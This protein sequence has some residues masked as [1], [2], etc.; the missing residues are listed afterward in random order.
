[1]QTRPNDETLNA[2]IFRDNL[3]KKGN[4]LPED[5][6]VPNEWYEQTSEI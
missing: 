3:M 5:K 4:H 1:M 2:G 6:K